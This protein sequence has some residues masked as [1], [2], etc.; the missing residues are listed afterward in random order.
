MPFLDCSA[1][2]RE[3]SSPVSAKF[4]IVDIGQ[5][6]KIDSLFFIPAYNQ[7]IFDSYRMVCVNN[8]AEDWSAL[9]FDHRFGLRV[10]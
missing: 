5:I 6:G 9:N 7:D 8:V 10:R 2:S 3:S 1:L 4:I